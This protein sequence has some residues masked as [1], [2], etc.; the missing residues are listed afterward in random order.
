MLEN[1]YSYKLILYINDTVTLLYIHHVLLYI[2][3]ILFGIDIILPY[4]HNIPVYIDDTDT[5]LYIHYVLLYILFDV[6]STLL[7]VN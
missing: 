6:N 3:N 2:N 5:L 4:A 7:H 1:H